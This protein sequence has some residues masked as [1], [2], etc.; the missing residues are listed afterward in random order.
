MN[1]EYDLKMRLKGFGSDHWQDDG[2][3]SYKINVGGGKTYLG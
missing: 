1:E 3:W 2:L